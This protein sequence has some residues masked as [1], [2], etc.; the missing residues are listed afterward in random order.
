MAAEKS[1]TSLKDVNAL[2]GDAGGL[3]PGDQ[4]TA[5][6]SLFTG[7]DLMQWVVEA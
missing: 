5:L 7:S 1:R 2:T 3:K 6:V 4:V